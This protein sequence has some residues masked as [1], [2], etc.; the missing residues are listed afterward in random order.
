MKRTPNLRL[1]LGVI[2]IVAGAGLLIQSHSVPGAI[3][4]LAMIAAG[5]LLILTARRMKQQ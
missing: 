1:I 5:V 4:A 3:G 2:A